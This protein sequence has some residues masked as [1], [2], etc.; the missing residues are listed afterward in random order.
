[1]PSI[2]TLQVNEK[3]Y[4]VQC[5]ALV[6]VTISMF[7]CASASINNK[8]VIATATIEALIPAFRR[9]DHVKSLKEC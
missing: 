3:D 4:R 6:T 5:Y 7:I 1:M 8:F 9:G 2:N